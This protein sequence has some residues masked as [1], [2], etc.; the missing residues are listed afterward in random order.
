MYVDLFLDLGTWR[1]ELCMFLTQNAPEFLDQSY[2]G[3]E[4]HCQSHVFCSIASWTKLLMEFIVHIG[5]FQ[6]VVWE[7]L[8]FHLFF[9][10]CTL[11]WNVCLLSSC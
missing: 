2:W 3:L 6:M 5:R 8:K 1:L 10:C 7:D 4:S 11:G 9:L